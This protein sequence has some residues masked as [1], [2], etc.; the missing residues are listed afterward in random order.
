MMELYKKYRP[1]TFDKVVGNEGTV[2]SLKNMLARKTLPRSILFHGPSGC[3]KTTLA[4]ILVR[5]LGCESLDVVEMNSS[6]FRGIDTVRDI[7]RNMNLA[8]TGPCRVWLIDECHKWTNDAQNA[9]LKML[10]DTPSHVYFFLCTTNPEKLIK[11]IRT[12]C[13][14]MP[15]RLLSYQELESLAGHVAKKEGID[16]SKDTLDSIV[17]SAQGSARMLLVLLDKIANLDEAQRA[18]AIAQQLEEENEAIDLCRALIKRA[19]WKTVADILKNIKAEPESTRRAVLGYAR[20]V[21]LSKAETQ[22]YMVLQ[23]FE[24]HFYDSGDAGLA[25]ACYESIMVE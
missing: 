3:G 20:S 1:R 8:P 12:R 22:A 11:A 17:A 24:G 4:R 15:V 14:E 21:L 13:C 9:A 25:R 5:E 23:A 18:E 2:A 19:P 16:L 6:S 10:E 7:C